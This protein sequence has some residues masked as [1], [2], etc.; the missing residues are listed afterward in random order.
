MP[1]RVC[2]CVIYIHTYIHTHEQLR[3]DDASARS[4][5]MEARAAADRRCVCPQHGDGG[6]QHALRGRRRFKGL[7]P[8]AVAVTR[9][10][11]CAQTVR[12]DA[13]ACFPVLSLCV[14][15][16]GPAKRKGTWLKDGFKEEKCLVKYAHG[17]AACHATVILF[18]ISIMSFYDPT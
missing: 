6:T 7:Q 12:A 15:R 17:T 4:M 1:I 18:N 9:H 14:V 11:H 5:V 2:S 8:H 13:L 16:W 3:I 10:T